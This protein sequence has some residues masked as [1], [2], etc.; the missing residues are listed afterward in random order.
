MHRRDREKREKLFFKRKKGLALPL[1]LSQAVQMMICRE[2]EAARK[3]DRRLPEERRKTEMTATRKT[4]AGRRK[5]E[6]GTF[7]LRN[8]RKKEK[9]KKKKK[10]ERSLSRAGV[11]SP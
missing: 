11:S 4:N 10:R 6:E 1:S 3:R 5:K 7:Q 9:K 2:G 8:R